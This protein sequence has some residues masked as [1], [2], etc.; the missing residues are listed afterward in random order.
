VIRMITG[1]GS[2]SNGCSGIVSRR[3]HGSGSI[4]RVRIDAQPTTGEV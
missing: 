4:A 1:A 3:G 2:V